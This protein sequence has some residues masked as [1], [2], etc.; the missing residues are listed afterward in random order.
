MVFQTQLEP[1]PTS[2]AS[3]FGITETSARHSTYVDFAAKGDTREFQVA[4]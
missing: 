3:L 1:A 4:S 2:A